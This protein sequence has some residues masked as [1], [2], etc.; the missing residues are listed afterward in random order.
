MNYENIQLDIHMVAINATSMHLIRT[1]LIVTVM[2][3][4]CSLVCLLVKGC[5][6]PSI[7]L[8]NKYYPNRRIRSQKCKSI[9]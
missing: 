6:V 3:F 4:S 9:S 8:V 5:N 2:M 1:I 7:L